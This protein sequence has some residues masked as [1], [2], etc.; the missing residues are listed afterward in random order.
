V[1]LKNKD[2][3]GQAVKNT[4]PIKKIFVNH[5]NIK[6]DDKTLEEYAS[7]LMNDK[8]F[9]Q[10]WLKM[11]LNTSDAD[12]LNLPDKRTG[13][14]SPPPYVKIYGCYKTFK[15]NQKITLSV[16][17]KDPSKINE[18][19]NEKQFSSELDV[20]TQKSNFKADGD[21]ILG[22]DRKNYTISDSSLYTKY[23]DS[24]IISEK[25]I[26]SSSLFREISEK[27]FE[28]VKSKQ[29]PGLKPTSTNFE[30][31]ILPDNGV[32]EFK[33][34]VS[35]SDSTNTAD[36]AVVNT[37]NFVDC[38]GND[39]SEFASTPTQTA[40]FLSFDDRAFTINCK[41]E[42][43]FY[44]NLYIGKESLEKINIPSDN[45]LPIR[46]LNWIFTDISYPKVAFSVYNRGIYSQLYR[47][48]I[49]LKSEKNVKAEMVNLKVLCFKV[50]N[51]K[52]EILMDENLTMD[53]LHKIFKLGDDENGFSFEILIEVLKSKDGR[54]KVLTNNY[55]QAIRSLICQTPFDKQRLIEIFT[56]LLRKDLF[57]WINSK[58][59]NDSIQFF[60]KTGFCLKNLLSIDNIYEEMD[61]NEKYAYSIGLI[62]GRYI[63]FKRNSNEESNSLK[64]ILSYS[65]YDREK[66]RYVFSR[67]GIGLSLSKADQAKVDDVSR[68]ISET[69]NDSQS[70]EEIND[71]SAFN[72]YSYFFFKG[73]YS[74]LGGHN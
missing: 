54:P 44:K 47:S 40:K 58:N 60:T 43:D 13:P 66:L 32:I 28:Y 22:L 36:S 7:E 74:Q 14:R 4:K 5:N 1:F 18:D 24:K 8:S 63:K 61:A 69:I 49:Q 11:P 2:F 20:V 35:L 15:T 31:Y 59:V 57:N 25:G 21:I 29:I 52:L 48:Y 72:D 17:G 6:I 53:K 38:F 16:K 19:D 9:V 51:A 45:V 70:K 26:F 73:V 34:S 67:V 39:C 30:L 41:Q 33:N 12:L 10:D 65:K 55:I 71:N 50:Q 27:F 68:F 62:A 42:T 64:D 46:G 37:S 56:R 3:K 23:L